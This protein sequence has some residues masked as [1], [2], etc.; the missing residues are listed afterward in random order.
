MKQ[1]KEAYVIPHSV[2]DL[3]PI[4]TV[5]PDGIFKVG[6]KY[7]KTYSFTD[8]NYEVSDIAIKEI[9]FRK[10]CSLLN[11]LDSQSTSKLTIYNRVINTSDIKNSVYMEDKQDGLDD[12]RHEYNALFQNE[13][14]KSTGKIQERFITITTAKRDI[15]EARLYFGRITAELTNK[16]ASLDSTCHELDGV[17]K[18]KLLHDIY[19]P[20]ETAVIDLDDMCQKGESFKD[21][22][23]PASIEKHSDYLVIGDKF[24]RTLYLKDYASYIKDSLINELTA[25]NPNM[26]LSIDIIPVPTDE[27]VREV[28][29]RLL[30]VET[31]ITNWVRKQNQNNNF[32]STIPY[33]MEMQRKETK[34][35]LS[36]LTSRDQR[37]MFAVVTMMITADTKEDLDI[38]TDSLL[39]TARKHMCQIATLKYQQLDGLNTALPIGTRNINAFRTLTTE[40][41]AVLMPFKVQEVNERGGVY[42]GINSKSDNIILC[43]REN[44]INQS[45]IILGI[46]G[47]GK[48]LCA[49]NLIWQQILNSDDDILICDPEG[50]Y[51]AMLNASGM[52][53]YSTVNLSSNGEDKLNA[54]YM[55]EGYGDTSPIPVKSQF[56]MSLIEQFDPSAVGPQHKSIIDR[57]VAM[58]Y[59]KCNSDGTVP[60]LSLLREI[61]LEQ[62]E[63]IA[64]DIALSLELYTSGNFDIFGHESTV[65]LDKRIVVFDM[66][67]LSPQIKS[68]ALLV[69]TDTILNRV[70]ENWRK[71]KRT[72][73]FIDEFHVFFDNP[74]SAQFFDSV[75]R[76]FRKRNAYPTAITQNV[77]SLLAREQASTMLSNSEFVVMFNQAASDRARLA[78]L[79]N[80]SGEQISFF[81][82]SEPGSGLIK[83]GGTLVPFR[84]PMPTNTKLYQLMTTRPGEG[85]FA[86]ANNTNAIFNTW[87]QY[88]G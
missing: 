64:K 67:E 46:P 86:K 87:E 8:I 55:V 50:E 61:L 59:E 49:K 11:S 63:S 7:S 62:K 37:M 29:A 77:Q 1:D 83:Y 41:L 20:G 24:V 6:N 42:M 53:D 65:N 23:C 12:L 43:N 58:V 68:A 45:A 84:S 40:S 33:D 81:T 35:F 72:H 70:T 47:S 57:C 3:I 78:S 34:E 60:T 16:F 85:V 5:Y 14:A 39:S 75:W 48:S 13:A 9:V 80:L 88:V 25:T 52:S 79:L 27:A 36:D 21:K 54:M 56:V 30:G 44:L 82:N 26:L 2:Q 38:K 71:G 19:C 74:Y 32:I 66:H 69:I 4:K 22:I 51:S 10:Y 18:L 15:Q 17:Q 28:E 31:N 73:I 76:Q